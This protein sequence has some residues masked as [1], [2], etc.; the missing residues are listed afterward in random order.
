MLAG[1]T[2]EYSAKLK[3][4]VGPGMMSR[5]KKLPASMRHDFLQFIG[6][7]PHPN[8]KELSAVCSG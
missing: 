8:C 5:V 7:V 1:S 2:C 3:E 6:N 4:I